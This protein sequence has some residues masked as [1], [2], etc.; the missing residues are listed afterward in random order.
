MIEYGAIEVARS[1]ESTRTTKW[2]T[3]SAKLVHALRAMLVRLHT[4]VNYD[5]AAVRSLQVVGL[6]NAGMNMQTVR[7][8]ALSANV[9]LLQRGKIRS[10]PSSVGGLKG[11]FALMKSVVMFKVGLV[12]ACVRTGG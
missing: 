7:M 9:F 1:F 2:L 5:P 3:D 10:V 11:V 12:C 6:L 8:S 4:L